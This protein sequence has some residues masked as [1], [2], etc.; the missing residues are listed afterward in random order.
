MATALLLGLAGCAEQPDASD[1]E[2]T[3]VPES[4]PTSTPA[5]SPTATT[6]S[7]APQPVTTVGPCPYLEQAYVEETIGQKVSSVE[8]TTTEPPVAPL[9]SCTFR[10]LNDEPAVVVSSEPHPS[11]LEAMNAALAKVGAAG[12]PVSEAGDGGAVLAADGQTVCAIAKGTAAIV[13]TI[14]Q[15]GSLE[16][17][18]IAGTVAASVP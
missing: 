6:D 3:A 2:A 8:V 4:A 16:A 5:P 7:P 17:E 12:N 1:V 13:I 14:N 9:P 15:E 11:P 18:E 10:A